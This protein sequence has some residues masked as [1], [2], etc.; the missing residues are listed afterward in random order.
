MPE[1]FQNYIL[2]KIK[3]ENIH[4]R[5]SPARKSKYG[6]YRYNFQQ[7]THA[8][9]V[10]IDLSDVKFMITFIHELAHKVCY[11]K[12]LGR[13]ASHGKEWK[14]VFVD[15]LKEAK[16]ILVLNE[17]QKIAFNK[18]ILNP[19]ATGDDFEIVDENQLLVASLPPETQFELKNGRQ[20]QLIKKRRTRFLCTDLSNGKLYAVAAK[21]QVER[22]L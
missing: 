14:A 20:F 16:A 8:I 11:D 18:T 5:L 3:A 17:E 21:A 4:L 9:S 2:E 13:V 10:N 1:D 22:I 6:D 12:H 7:K 19:K 15:L